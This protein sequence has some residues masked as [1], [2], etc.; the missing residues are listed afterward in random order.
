M[1]ARAIQP[2]NFMLRGIDQPPTGKRDSP[3]SLLP[4]YG[5]LF[6]QIGAPMGAKETHGVKAQY[7]QF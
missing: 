2:E 5:A 1:Q 3:K 4:N 7:Q 6:E